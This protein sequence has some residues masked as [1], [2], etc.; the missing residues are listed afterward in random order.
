MRTKITVA[1]CILLLSACESQQ[2]EAKNHL[3]KGKEFF[4]KGEFDKSLLELKS[5]TQDEISVETYYYLALLDEKHNKLRSARENLQKAVELDPSYAEARVK[6]AN[7]LILFGDLDKAKQQAESVLKVNPDNIEAKLVLVSI[8]IRENKNADADRIIAYVLKDNPNNLEALY[9]KSNQLYQQQHIEEALSL[10]DQMLNID[11]ENQPSRLLRI[12]INGDKKNIDG[13]VADYRELIKLFPNVE[14][15]KLSLAG[16]Y[17]RMDD[18]VTA[19]ALLR[20]MVEKTPTSIEPKIFLLEFL[21][22]RSKE[23]VNDEYEKMLLS[24]ELSANQSLG[25]ARWMLANGFIDSAEKGLNKL[26]AA[27]N[28]NAVSFIG[29]ALKALKHLANAEKVSKISLTAQT[30]LAEISLSKKQYDIVESTIDRILNA[31]SDFVDATLL[32]A[33]L[34]LVQN[35]P[36]AAIEVLNKTIWTKNSSDVAYELLGDAFLVKKDQKQAEKNF[37]QALEI[38]PANLGAFFPVYYGLMKSNQKES[39]LQSLNKALNK[40]PYQEQL[41]TEK[42]NI[43]ILEKNWNTAQ[44]DLGQLAFFSKNKVAITNMQ[45]NILQGQGQYAEAIKLYEKLLE[46]Y[47]ENLNSLVNLTRAFETL[48]SR[49]KLIA[50]LEVHHANHPESLIIMS[51]LGDV[52]ISNKDYLKTE[53]L[54][55]DQIKRMPNSV[56]LYL[57]LA[58]IEILVRKNLEG[59]KDVYLKGLEV[60]PDDTKLLL[61]LGSWYD[62]VGDKV[63]ARKTYE[64]LLEKFPDNKPGRN[65]LAAL[66]ADSGNTEDA[67][68][69]RSLSEI[70]K[71]DDNPFYQDTYAWALA[72]TGHQ[73]EALKLLESIILKEPKSPEIRY[74]LGVAHYKSGNTATAI[75]E[76]KK[77]INLS[78]TQHR[79]FSGKSDAKKILQELEHSG[80][81]G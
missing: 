32:K 26:I 50:Y 9:L 62:Q 25:L 65:N 73:A 34:F 77:A 42:L 21:N 66:L 45:A 44:E 59:A 11:S 33:R 1:I 55:T 30:L 27:E 39:A 18:L 48:K 78:E 7:V 74:H 36:D 52:Y 29:Q 35:K 13:V 6:L 60:I 76:L 56:P 49:D 5:S 70:F 28:D 10:L 24:G 23:R 12:R 53:Q 80:Q 38:N 22:A 54:Y 4:E 3:Q 40:M 41:L 2:E 20:E 47:P 61:A 57:E 8:N 37:K 14:K 58:K 51:V 81:K 46:E 72:K 79:N 63:N 67:I 71:N 68:K 64:H 17:A 16:I 31:D 19:E 75:A 69:G 43:D 15:F